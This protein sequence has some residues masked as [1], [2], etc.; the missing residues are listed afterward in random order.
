MGL[1]W[2]AGVGVSLWECVQG[3]MLICNV[4][5]LECPLLA[6]FILVSF[7]ICC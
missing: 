5:S 7:A 2:G 3:R 1:G 4:Q 6:R